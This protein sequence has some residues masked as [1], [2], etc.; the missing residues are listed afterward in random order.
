MDGSVPLDRR[1]WLVRRKKPCLW[2]VGRVEP[3]GEFGGR[4]EEAEERQ[5]FRASGSA[6]DRPE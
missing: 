5:G 4:G 3:E 1:S 6:A 2:W